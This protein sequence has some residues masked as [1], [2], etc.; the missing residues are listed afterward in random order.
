M[1]VKKFRTLVIASIR[2]E[3]DCSLVVLLMFK[4][5]FGVKHIQE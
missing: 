4:R 1:G 5:V 3:C 2:V